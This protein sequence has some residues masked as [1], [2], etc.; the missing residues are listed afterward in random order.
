MET[1]RLKAGCC[2]PNDTSSRGASARG[3]HCSARQKKLRRLA[4]IKSLSSSLRPLEAHYRVE[5]MGAAAVHRP[6][7]PRSA[8]GFR[9][10][11]IHRNHMLAGADLAKTFSQ[12]AVSRQPR[13]VAT[14]DLHPGGRSART[15]PPV[16]IRAI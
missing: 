8:L 10:L 14:P 15:C 6:F 7:L 4:R 1:P 13:A 12:V 3:S 16:D 9:L 11:S 5:F 2:L